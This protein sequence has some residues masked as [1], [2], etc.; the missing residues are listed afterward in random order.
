MEKWVLDSFKIYW[1]PYISHLG[2]FTQSLQSKYID[3]GYYDNRAEVLRANDNGGKIPEFWKE[4][5]LGCKEM[6]WNKNE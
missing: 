6:T 2:C 4:E 5:T 1:R 3:T